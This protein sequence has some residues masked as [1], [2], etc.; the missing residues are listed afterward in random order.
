M[1]DR[2]HSGNPANVCLRLGEIGLLVLIVA[3][4]FF[5]IGNGDFW[6]HMR[7]GKWIVDHRAVPWENLYMYT[8]EGYPW[9]NHSW[10]T[11][12]AFYGLWEIGGPAAEQLTLVL[13][14]AASYVVLYV[15]YRRSGAP[16]WLGLLIF[17]TGIA[18]ARSRYD[19]RPEMFSGV[20]VAGFLY[21]LFEFKSGRRTNLWPVVPLLILWANFHGTT[22]TA[23]L[24]L[25]VF[26]AAEGVQAHF[27]RGSETKTP[28]T[29]KQ[30]GHVCVMIP[31]S[32]LLILINPFGW[33]YFLSLDPRRLAVLNRYLTEWHSLRELVQGFDATTV[34]LMVAFGML[35]LF[36]FLVARR[37]FQLSLFL[38]TLLFVTMAVKSSRQI[39]VAVQLLVCVAAMNFSCLQ[40]RR[41]ANGPEPTIPAVHS[42]GLAFACL[43]M[44]LTIVQAVYFSTAAGYKYGLGVDR[45][46]VPAGAVR[47]MQDN[48]IRGRLF[49]DEVDS[50]YLAWHL[51]PSQRIFI[52]GMNAYGPGMFLAAQ[53]LRGQNV[54][55]EDFD[56]W[57]FDV[58]LIP[59]KPYFT[60]LA[61]LLHRR[62][63]WALVYWDGVS[64][65]FVNREPMY[66]SLIGAREY[67]DI[68]PSLP[69][70][71]PE[72]FRQ[73]TL[74]E[75]HRS[76]EN[77]V[78]SAS[79]YSAAGIF[80]LAAQ[81]VDEA[82]MN[83]QRALQLRPTSVRAMVGMAKC[84][85]RMGELNESIR[86]CRRILFLQ[87]RMSE[88][89][90]IL[91]L[92]RA[93][94]QDAAGTVTALEKAVELGRFDV[95]IGEKLSLAYLT[96]GEFREAER[97]LEATLALNP[98]SA[99]LL[100]AL[101]VT[102]THS[103]PVPEGRIFDSLER[104]V[105][106]QPG[107][108]NL[109]RDEASFNGLRDH[110]RYQRLLSP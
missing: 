11:G 2:S 33:K 22:L 12:I 73:T 6:T 66:A 13:L 97:L 68:D 75:V 100:F 72:A 43:C 21:Y 27:S 95:R 29:R 81:S 17:A 34:G 61:Q 32:V 86:W 58:A 91:G 42:R 80:C 25:I 88:A 47:F 57:G 87:P 8:A 107:M 62:N 90:I 79:L 9:I 48:R 40:A 19:L 44:G 24:I 69:D 92:S 59:A 105:T 51:Y 14:L 5:H 7:T 26:A 65:L 108:R 64:W 71:F 85:R 39:W 103:Q 102:L 37:S 109:I 99:P 4:C 83:F 1:H 36:S 67:H 30:I 94:L 52:D 106:L 45:E 78:K 54:R 74:R 16:G 10:L 53:A 77:P 76:L 60:P 56:R 84:A 110:P 70:A 96:R 38:L 101:A 23:T 93:D 104:S 28:L 35:V 98:R 55:S 41:A 31:L 89:W 49:N 50:G 20:L 82:R 15:F 63:D 18:T 46:Y 3:L